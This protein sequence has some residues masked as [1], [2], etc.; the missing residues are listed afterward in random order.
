MKE[1]DKGTWYKRLKR[2]LRYRLQIP[3]MRGANTPEYTARGVMIGILW[4]MTPFLGI[5]MLLILIT[6][7]VLSRLIQWKFSLVNALA[8][9]WVT[10]IFTVIP[11]FYVFYLTGQIMLGQFDQLSGYDS[12]RNLFGGLEN[13]NLNFLQLSLHWLKTLISD[14]GWPLLLGSIPW[15]IAC[16]SLAYDFSLRFIHRYRR[17]RELRMMGVRRA[18]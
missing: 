5:Q 6:W 4:A 14:I 15:S 18:P 10:N 17:S 11:V 7:F 16:A 3:I 12:F 8:W 13:H 9:V 2:G 1:C